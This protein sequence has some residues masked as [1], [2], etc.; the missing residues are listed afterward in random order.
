MIGN[1]SV[2][3]RGEAGAAAPTPAGARPS[4]A[5]ALAGELDAPLE[6]TYLTGPPLFWRLLAANLFVVLGGALVGTAL[7]RQFVISGT[8]SV[9]T[10]ALMV[11]VA[12]S[13]SALLTAAILH[14]AFRPLRALREAIEQAPAPGRTTPTSRLR[15]AEIDQFGDPDILA[16]ASA[17]RGLWDR[18][19]QHVRLL[20]DSN[21]RL[22]E[23]RHE[24]AEKTVQLQRLASLVLAAQEEERRRVARELHDETMQS[25]AALIMG[26]E[27]ALQ[28]IPE[29][30]PDAQAVGAARQSITRLQDLAGR[31]LDELRHLALDLRPSVLDDHGLIAAVRWLARVHQ[32]RSGLTCRV[33]LGGVLA[34][35][36]TKDEPARRLPPAVETA[37]FRITQEA[38]ANVAKH[39]RASHVVI[40]LAQTETCVTVEIEDDGIGLSSAQDGRAARPEHMGLFNMRERAALLGGTCVIRRRGR[41]GGTVVRAELPLVPVA[42]SS[43]AG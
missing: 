16:V 3:T 7:T 25:M 9:L 39:A 38:L 10:Q 31:M 32:D 18:L 23:Q 13:L 42:A 27:Q 37:L 26:L 29:S 14:I 28:G 15:R 8:F 36:G 12:M 19:D 24:L 40:R 21:R 22:Q 43:K 20:E 17:V 1:A 30:G 6:P 34:E 5:P 35:R 41:A 2:G 11:L 4:D 33:E